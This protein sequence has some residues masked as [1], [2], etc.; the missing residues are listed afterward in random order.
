MR[1]ATK[2]K[3]LSFITKDPLY[4]YAHEFDVYQKFYTVK[5]GDI[6]IDAGA[7]TGYVSLLFSKLAGNAGKVYAFEPDAINIVHIKDNIAL[8]P[9]TDNII[10]DDL[11]LWNENTFIDF[12]ESGTVGSSALWLPE[13]DKIVKKQTITIDDWA[14]RNNIPKIDFIKMNIEGAEIEAVEGCIET[15]R[16]SQPDFA[17]Y[18][19]HTVGGELT[20][21]KLESFFKSINYPYKTISK[22]TEIVTYAG[23]GIR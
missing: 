18:S 20:Y 23:G 16:N 22:G 12:Y 1:F 21:I 10:I 17:I 5:P 3:G 15:I 8:N 11:L 14:R 4:G 13:S 9:G 2:Y 6:V 19:N 7:N